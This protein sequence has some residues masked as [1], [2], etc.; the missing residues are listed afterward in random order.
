MFAGYL[1]RFIP[2]DDDT[3]RYRV[4]STEKV[5]R[6]LHQGLLE[7]VARSPSTHGAYTKDPSTPQCRVITAGYVQWGYKILVWVW[8]ILLQAPARSKAK[9]YFNS[10]MAHFALRRPKLLNALSC[11]RDEVMP[12]FMHSPQIQKI[13]RANVR[14]F[15]R[16]GS[17]LYIYIFFR[18]DNHNPSIY[19]CIY[20]YVYVY[21]YMYIYIYRY[22]YI[23]I[24]IYIYIN[25]YLYIYIYIIYA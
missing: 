4:T 25:T 17:Y 21:I 8:D 3:S 18:K 10:F 14:S 23:Y 20:V 2:W 7:K 22:K 11:S 19:I 24:Y 12:S 15:L 9:E 1:S 5:A 16:C 13:A 6:L